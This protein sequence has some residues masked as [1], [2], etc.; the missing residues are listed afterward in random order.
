MLRVPAG[1]EGALARGIDVARCTV[2]R[3]MRDHGIQGA[4]RRGKPWRTTTPDPAGGE[5]PDLVERD[6]TALAPDRLWVA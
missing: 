5:A 4:R 3:L 6:F 1:V 2:E